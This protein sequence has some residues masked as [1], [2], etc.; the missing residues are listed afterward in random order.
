MP[1]LSFHTFSWF[2]EYV[3]MNPM[4]H[5]TCTRLIGFVNLVHSGCMPSPMRNNICHPF[6][7]V[8]I[9]YVVFVRFLNV[10]YDFD[11]TFEYR[12]KRPSWK[13]LTSTAI[14]TGHSGHCSFMANRKTMWKIDV[15]MDFFISFINKEFPNLISNS[16]Y[17]LFGYIWQ[18]PR[19][20]FQWKLFSLANT[21]NKLLIDSICFPSVFN[22]PLLI[23]V[24]ILLVLLYYPKNHLFSCFSV[25]LHVC[26]S[27]RIDC[28]K[29]RVA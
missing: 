26:V 8:F 15:S 28:F 7:S 10:P 1:L 4:H 19:T 5:E 2:C 24:H 13:Y 16:F 9:S 20:S 14:I 6:P 29:I 17:S 23:G 11:G 21:T 27:F 22:L 12:T 25:L 3:L 18:L